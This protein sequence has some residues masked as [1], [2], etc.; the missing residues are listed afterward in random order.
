MKIYTIVFFSSSEI[1]IP[2]LKKLSADPRFKVLA[3][4]TQPDKEFGRDKEIKKTATKIEAENLGIK[5][6]QPEKLSLE[7]EL[8]N[9]VKAMKPDF[10][11]TFAYGQMMN[12]D[13]LA[14]PVIAPINVHASL[15]P[16][17]RG[18]SPIQM[19]ILNGDKKS[20][21]S[22]MRMVKKMDAG[23][24]YAQ[25]EIDINK[26]TSDELFARIANLAAE[27]TSEDLIKIAEGLNSVEQNETE[28]TYCKKIS[29]EEG[30]LNF[31]QSSEEVLRMFRA[32]YPWPG[33]WAKFGEKRIK[34]LKIEKSERKITAGKVECDSGIYVGT[35]DASIKV[36]E[37]QME[38]KKAMDAKSF[39]SGQQDICGTILL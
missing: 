1:S 9:E 37:L 33:L 25:H 2:L 34:F 5:I 3:L 24:F 20:G 13:W 23:P 10:F 21:I 17:Y 26:E 32:Y 31:E 18:A 35:K 11:L 39:L 15:L 27:K 29:R 6:Y 4:F 12:D 8:L 14:V 36:L 28:A 19:S 38:G 22:I 30:H 16:K 7:I